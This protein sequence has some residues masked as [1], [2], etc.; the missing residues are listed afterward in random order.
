MKILNKIKISG[1]AIIIILFMGDLFISK[2]QNKKISKIKNEYLK[3]NVE[4]IFLKK[5]KK[6]NLAIISNRSVKEF[7]ELDNIGEIIKNEPILLLKNGKYGYIK[8]NG[9]I[10]I[11]IDY[12]AIGIF[13][14]N[15]ALV[16]KN[17]KIGVLNKNGKMVLPLKYTEIY[18]GENNN[19]ILKGQDN[20]YISY[21]LKE[22]IILN[23]DKIYKINEKMVVFSEKN[24]FGIMNYQGEII[25]PN[26]FDEISTFIDRLFIGAKDSKYSLYNLKNEKKSKDY[27][28]IEQIGDNVYKGGNIEKGNYAFL[29]EHMSTEEKY[30]DIRKYNETIYIGELEK[31]MS[32]IIEVESKS[33]KTIKN[34]DIEKYIKKIQEEKSNE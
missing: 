29:S 12:D 14:D 7:K 26:I 31:N 13:I 17:E 32:D 5:N 16:K 8:P 33:I 30:E 28:F 2:I 3:T 27:D 19:F 6:I 1:L 10:L 24:K 4:N 15:K 9:D 20:Q 18:I 25:I 11:P 22:K 23:V 34:D 21:N